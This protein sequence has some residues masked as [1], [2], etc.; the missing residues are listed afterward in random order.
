MNRRVHLEIR[1]IGEEHMRAPVV[2]TTPAP[3]STEELAEPIQSIEAEH[4]PID[5]LVPSANA[6]EGENGSPALEPASGS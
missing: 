5:S 1:T 6:S 2:A 4:P 3:D